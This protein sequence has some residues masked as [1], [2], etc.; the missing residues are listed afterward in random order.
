V[1]DRGRIAATPKIHKSLVVEGLLLLVRRRR[2]KRRRR[3]YMLE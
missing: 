3:P 1:P 2:R